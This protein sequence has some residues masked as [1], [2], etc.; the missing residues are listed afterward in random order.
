MDAYSPALLPSIDS[1][2]IVSLESVDAGRVD[3]YM[4]NAA[5]APSITL[6]GADAQRIADLWRLLPPGDQARCHFPPYGLRFR[7]EGRVI[8]EASICWECDNIFGVADGRH[9]H[10]AFD[11]SHPTSTRLLAELRQFSESK[12]PTY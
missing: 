8:S 12:K 11:A 3:E 7:Y 10:Y 5:D 4:K 9:I 1:V 2:E 6:E